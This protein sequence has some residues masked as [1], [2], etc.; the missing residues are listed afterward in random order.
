MAKNRTKGG[1]YT[2]PKQRPAVD[3]LAGFSTFEEISLE[4][5]SPGDDCSAC[6]AQVEHCHG[7]EVDHQDGTV[8]CSFGAEC[9]GADAL[10]VRGVSCFL[11]GPCDRCG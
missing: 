6:A 5:L 7:V 1:R 11:V 3:P 4:A 9:L 2:P 8:S 10:H